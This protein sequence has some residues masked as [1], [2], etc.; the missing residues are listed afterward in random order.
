MKKYWKIINIL[1]LMF[2]T[3]QTVWAMN[4]RRMGGYE[5]TGD[6]Y[7]ALE[8]VAEKNAKVAYVKNELKLAFKMEDCI[9]VNVEA[10]A[11]FDVGT[12]G[13]IEEKIVEENI[14]AVWDLESKFGKPPYKAKK[15]TVQ[16]DGVKVEW[17]WFF[18]T[19]KNHNAN[20]YDVELTK[21]TPT[22]TPTP[23]SPPTVTPVPENPLVEKPVSDVPPV[24]EKTP[25]PLV[26][27]TKGNLPQ[28]Q[29][30]VTGVPPYIPPVDVEQNIEQSQNQDQQQDQN[31]TNV[32]PN[33]CNPTG[34]P[35]PPPVIPSPVPTQC[36]PTPPPAITTPQ[37]PLQPTTPPNSI[38]IRQINMID[39]VWMDRKIEWVVIENKKNPL[40][41]G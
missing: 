5:F 39:P 12:F 37:N 41:Y 24:V 6:Q 23:V 34:T 25:I 4:W 40:K 30:F 8:I 36:A 18:D 26:F 21:P 20:I 22:V 28:T 15:Y 31:Q 27:V 35:P 33:T 1:I 19:C 2:I 7:Q 13:P 3:T 29:V 16:K 9:I 11:V 14:V 38:L 17:F 32:D 10:G